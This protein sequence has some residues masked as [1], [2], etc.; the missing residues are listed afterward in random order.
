[1]FRPLKKCPCGSGMYSTDHHDARGLFLVRAC[2][3]CED[4]KLGQFRPEVLTN[5]NY[6]ADEPIEEEG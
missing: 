6:E 1:M 4:Q 5:F 2:P 3:R